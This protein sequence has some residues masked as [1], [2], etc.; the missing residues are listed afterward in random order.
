MGEKKKL[1]KSGLC[2]GR[3]L[4]IL[5]S[6]FAVSMVIRTTIGILIKAIWFVL[7]LDQVVVFK[8]HKYDQ[9]YLCVLIKVAASI[10]IRG[11]MTRI[12]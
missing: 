2:I 6:R 10:L 11:R 3:D 12:N 9:V 4:C 8:I 5:P 7:P 1:N